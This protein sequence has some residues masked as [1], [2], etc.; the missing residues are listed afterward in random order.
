MLSAVRSKWIT[1]LAGVIAA[2]VLASVAIG[3]SS[4]DGK[5][6]DDPRHAV[7]QDRDRLPPRARHPRRPRRRH[8]TA[9]RVPTGP[10]LGRGVVARTSGRRHRRRLIR[11]LVPCRTYDWRGGGREALRE[12]GRRQGGMHRRAVR[13]REALF[14]PGDPPP[15]VPREGSRLRA[16][17]LAS[18]TVNAFR[19]RI[20]TFVATPTAST[21][22]TSSDSSRSAARAHRPAPSTPPPATA[23]SSTARR[24]RRTA[25]GTVPR[26]STP[27][28][29]RSRS[30]STGPRPSPGS[31]RPST[32][33][34]R[35]RCS[36][37]PTDATTCSRRS[38]R[39]RGSSCDATTGRRG[40]SAAGGS[41]AGHTT[42]RGSS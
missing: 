22:E 23:E 41:P 26:G 33:P 12:G 11:R 19:P 42:M 39:T 9:R 13:L 34:P 7:S 17:A 18:S 3:L 21:R 37:A 29:R 1:M 24:T 28:G 35:F 38:R 40:R 31:W 5:V 6:N 2:V 25:T 10:G 20:N 8:R 27:R 16:A 4:P 32:R 30:A 14:A 15:V 36:T